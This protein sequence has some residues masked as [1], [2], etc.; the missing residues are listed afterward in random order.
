[1]P[2]NDFDQDGADTTAGNND[3][4]NTPRVMSGSTIARPGSPGC[5]SRDCSVMEYQ[6]PLP[7]VDD[8]VPNY[9]QVRE[10]C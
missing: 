2:N 1:V 5:K 7:G 4:G 8:A 9:D 6:L 10:G 3:A